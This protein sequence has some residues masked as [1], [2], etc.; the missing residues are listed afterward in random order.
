VSWPVDPGR[1]RDLSNPAGGRAD[2]VR[3]SARSV[4]C[5]GEEVVVAVV[6]DT[7]WRDYEAV[8]IET[9]NAMMGLLAGAQL[10]SHLLQLMK[11]SD[12]LLPEVYP[13]VPHIG[14]FN[15]TSEA[16]SEILASADAHL[17]A[18]SVPYALSVH[19]DY[20]KTCLTLLARAGLST[21]NVANKTVLAGQH[22][23]IQQATG[24][25]FDTAAI[26][27]LDTLRKMRNCTIHAG[28]RASETLVAHLATLPASVATAWV[29]LA[30]RDPRSL[31]AY[32]KRWSRL[33]K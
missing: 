10:A 14:R 25:S 7:A 4:T 19:E 17:G 15:L 3:V 12:R 5:P 6:K 22:E 18:M 28:G 2:R 20:L 33:K 16:A 9:S 21:I 30:K 24:G 13:L 29:K 31:E 1:E 11:G 32:A 23:A 8:R 26:C 27:Q